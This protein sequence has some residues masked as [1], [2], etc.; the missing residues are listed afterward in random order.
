MAVAHILYGD[1]ERGYFY[2]NQLDGMLFDRTIN[3]NKLRA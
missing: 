1:R 3:G 2:S